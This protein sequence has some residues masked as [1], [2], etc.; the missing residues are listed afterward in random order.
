[1]ELLAVQPLARAWD[2]QSTS[3]LDCQAQVKLEVE[4]RLHN[5]KQEGDSAYFALDVEPLWQLRYYNRTVAAI[6]MTC[7]DFLT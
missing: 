5:H 2:G 6:T 3:G 7:V 4:F 1:M